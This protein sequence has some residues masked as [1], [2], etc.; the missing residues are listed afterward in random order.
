MD[1]AEDN[2]LEKK[3]RGDQDT[4]MHCCSTAPAWESDVSTAKDTVAP[5]TG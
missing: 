5:G 3:A 4:W 2:F 1:L